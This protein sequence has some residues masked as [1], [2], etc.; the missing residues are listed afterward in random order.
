MISLKSC[1]SFQ[2]R[3]SVATIQ[4]IHP[5]IYIYIYPFRNSCSNIVDISSA[6]LRIVTAKPSYP[7]IVL[8]VYKKGIVRKKK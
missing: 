6:S 8:Y 7:L 1:V 3:P 5:S 2:L 4:I